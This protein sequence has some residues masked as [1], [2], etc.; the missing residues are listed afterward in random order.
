MP[1]IPSV[2]TRIQC[3]NCESGNRG[4]VA[5]YRLFVEFR[6]APVWCSSPTPGVLLTPCHDEF[7]GPRS[8][9]VRQ[10]SGQGH[11]LMTGVVTSWTQIL[12]VKPVK[13]EITHIRCGVCQ[14]RCPPRQTKPTVH[15][16][17]RS[18]LINNTTETLTTA[19]TL[20]NFKPCN[21]N[22]SEVLQFKAVPFLQG[23]PGAVTQQDNDPRILLGMFISFQQI[24]LLSRPPY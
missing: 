22:I 16:Q 19:H 1:Q 7:R 3:L 18:A 10:P 5:I 24:Q 17:R 11:E 13:A 20:V 6:R 9:Y 4:G 14:L 21:R 8:D 2:Y 23:I 12:L 15:E